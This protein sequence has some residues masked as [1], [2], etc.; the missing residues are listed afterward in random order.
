METIADYRPRLR[1][2]ALEGGRCSRCSFAMAPM[3]PRCPACS[4]P[5]EATTFAPHGRVWSSTVIHIAVG[6]LAA[7][8]GLAYV[9][10][11]DGPRVLARFT[12]AEPMPIGCSVTLSEHDN[13]LQVDRREA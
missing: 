10:V 4:G 12:G 7:P 5:V 11:A 1:D 13:A 9:D 6:D 2:G 3:M 8:F